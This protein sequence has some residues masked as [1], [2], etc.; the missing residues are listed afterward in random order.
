M[1][2]AILKSAQKR[3]YRWFVFKPS[4]IT[5]RTDSGGLFFRKKNQVFQYLKEKRSD[6]TKT[7]RNIATDPG[8]S[9]E[10]KDPERDKH[11]NQRYDCQL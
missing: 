6:K 7:K 4:K 8:L 1:E 11:L 2:K 10:I 5:E 9:V 3:L